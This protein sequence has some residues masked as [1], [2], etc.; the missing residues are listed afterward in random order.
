MPQNSHIHQWNGQQK[1]YQSRFNLP[2]SYR[3]F[4]MVFYTCCVFCSIIMSDCIKNKNK[5]HLSYLIVSTILSSL[6]WIALVYTTPSRA[7]FV[8]L[9]VLLITQKTGADILDTMAVAKATHANRFFLASNEICHCSCVIQISLRHHFF[10]FASWFF[11]N[12]S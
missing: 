2:T 9:A 8:Y 11:L 5:I 12:G 6:L 1:K 7:S 10:L 4:N 3:K